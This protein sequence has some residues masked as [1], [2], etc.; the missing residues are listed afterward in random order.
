MTGLVATFE[1]TATVTSALSDAEISAIETEVISNFDVN[2][3]E[4]TTTGIVHE[5]SF[6][7][8]SFE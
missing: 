1:V 2:S 3:D 4:V 7:L 6:T 8:I 5:F